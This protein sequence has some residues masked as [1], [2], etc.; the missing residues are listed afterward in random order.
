MKTIPFNCD[1]LNIF[2]IDCTMKVNIFKLLEIRYYT[3]LAMHTFA[4]ES[5]GL[6]G[7]KK[8]K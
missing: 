6:T 3:V 8:R 4:L 5:I 2:N 1:H 7:A